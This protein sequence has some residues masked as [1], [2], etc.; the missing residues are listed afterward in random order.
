MAK[1]PSVDGFVPR[2]ST[3]TI[4][5][6]LHPEVHPTSP[7]QSGLKRRTAQHGDA[8][9]ADGATGLTITDHGLSHHPSAISHSDIS[10]SLR[11]IDAQKESE[12]KKKRKRGGLVSRR[13]AITRA[14][15]IF[16]LLIVLLIGGWM[17]VKALMASHSVFKGDIFGL[18]QQKQLKKDTNGRTNVLIFGTSEDDEG[19]DHPGAYLTDSI[20]VLSIDQQKKDAYMVSI[21]RDLWVQLGSGCE[22]GY[23]AKINVLFNCFSEQGKKQDEGANALGKKVSEITGLDIQYHV[24]VNYTVVREA[25]DAVG[26]VSVKVESNPPGMGILDRNFDWKCNYKC[27]YVKYKDGE[28]AQMDGEHA[29]AFMRARNAQGGY[30]LAQGNFDREKNQQK[31]VKAL[32]EKA[33]SAGTLANPAR[34]TALIDAMGKNLSTNFETSEIRTLMSLGTDIQSDAITSINLVDEKN[35][36][37]TTGNYNGQSIVRPVAGLYD[38]TDVAAYI[39]KQI[40]ADPVAKET[41]NVVVLN[42]SGV[43]GAAKIAAD[44]L[45]AMGFTVADIGD[46]PAGTYANRE[47]YQASATGNAA[48][49]AKLTS[50]YGTPKTGVSQFGLAGDVDFVVVIGKATQTQ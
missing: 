46:A 19:G 41:A 48:T 49:R 20:M 13:K 4:G 10:D 43:S 7:I 39:K 15:L 25:V 37:M 45:E 32:R 27:Y 33:L 40:S 2:R 35:P 3:N 11:E 22:D 21:P 31:V 50:L 14:I 26:G 18:I 5:R 17:A 6:A 44:K 36:M 29:L 47:V 38:Y 23:Q 1:K 8:K 28:V 16:I 12:L 42:G 34:I 9:A 24:H 30:G